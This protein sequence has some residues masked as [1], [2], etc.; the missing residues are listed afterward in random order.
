MIEQQISDR[1]RDAVADEPPLGF[2]PDQVVDRAG[3]R[4]RS[5]RAII[6]TMAATSAVAVAAVAVFATGGEQVQVAGPNQAYPPAACL[7]SAQDA[8]KVHR[9]VRQ[10]LAEHIPGTRFDPE[11]RYVRSTS[12]SG[13]VCDVSVWHDVVGVTPA[14]TVAVSLEYVSGH[15]GD[16]I[17]DDPSFERVRETH[18]P[19]GSVLRSYGRKASADEQESQYAGIA[20]HLRPNDMVIWASTTDLRAASVEELTALVT[21]PRLTF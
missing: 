8:N 20:V 17:A 2:D 13:A 3:S 5:R 1:L 12:D 15:G 16:P 21:D 10:A 4:Q 14:Q 11:A 19:D 9:L 18:N 6:G 7:D